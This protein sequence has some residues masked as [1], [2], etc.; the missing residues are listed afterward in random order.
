MNKYEWLG[1]CGTCQEAKVVVNH[2]LETDYEIQTC[3]E[4]LAE[5]FA[6]MGEEEE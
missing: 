1:L 4:C 2:P 3:N 5:E 6:Q